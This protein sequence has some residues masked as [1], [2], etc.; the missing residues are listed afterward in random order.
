M[1]TRSLGA[2]LRSWSHQL[3]AQSFA[4]ALALAVLLMP[5]C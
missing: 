5:A 1:R 4:A 3:S 2:P